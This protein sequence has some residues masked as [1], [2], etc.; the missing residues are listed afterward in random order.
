MSALTAEVPPE[1]I[2]SQKEISNYSDTLF[3]N[4]NGTRSDMY[5]Q[6]YDLEIIYKLDFLNNSSSSNSRIYG[7]DNL[8]IKLNIDIEKSA[9]IK[10]ASALLQILSNRGDKPGAHSNRLPHGLDNIETPSNGNTT[11]LYQAWLQQL[12]LDERISL[13]AGLYDLN[14]EF[15]A[16]ESSGIFIHPTFGIGA[17]MAGTGKNGPS[18]FPTTSFGL[19]LKTI[20]SAGYYLQLVTLDGVPGDPNN[21]Q[22]THVQFNEGDGTLNVI[23]GGI[24][25]SSVENAHNNKL[26]LG[27]WRYTATFDDILDVDAS[28]N[29]IKKASHG[30]YAIIDKVFKYQSDATTEMI[31]GFFRFGSTE[32][33]TSQFDHAMSTG[34]VWTGTFPGR[35][36]DK[37]GI[38]YA[39]EHNSE[40]YRIASGNQVRYENSLELGYMYRARNG[41]VIQPFVQY[42]M[43]HSSDIS[44]DKTWWLGLRIQASF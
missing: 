16:T 23:E 12:F 33:D 36:Q 29:P 2:S 24:P 22:G 44:Q 35:E 7:L 10:G 34:V 1:G 25:L 32:G 31:S 37:L 41:L 14:S 39:Q 43:N 9:G 21:P 40:K 26:A 20:P 15:Y 11:K 13:L 4:W 18:I 5:S 42:L 8:D 38:A 27:I 30:I 17:E 6:G 28:G 19:R 3:G